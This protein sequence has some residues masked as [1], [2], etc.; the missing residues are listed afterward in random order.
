[1]PGG[2]KQPKDVLGVLVGGEF[3]NKKASIF[4]MDASIGCRAPDLQELEFSSPSPSLGP[5]PDLKLAVNVIDVFFNR[6]DR[7]D[8]LL[9]NFSIGITGRHPPQDV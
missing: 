8:Q 9:R 4:A 3:P 2:R 7:D 1:M 6:T 5:I